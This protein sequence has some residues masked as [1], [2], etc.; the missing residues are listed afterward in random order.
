MND[1]IF[2]I[3]LAMAPV[4]EL[5][6]SIPYGILR[7]LPAFPVILVSIVFN[8]IA[9]IVVF[10]FLDKFVRFFLNFGIFRK[11][12]SKI[13]ERSQKKIHAQVEKYGWMGVALF[14]GIPLPITGAWTGA[15][16]SYLIGLD[17][18][19][20]I[21]SIILGV[22]AASIII[23]IVTLSGASAFRFFVKVI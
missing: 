23:S 7:G 14:V 2:V 12:Y 19:K 8:I 16:G 21:I 15:L 13:V 6:G 11:Y 5:R 9:G 3:L 18:K 10:L 17:K 20:T 1:W 4:S 22:I